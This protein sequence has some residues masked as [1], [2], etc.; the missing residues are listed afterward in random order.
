MKML[1]YSS[2]VLSAPFY[3]VAWVF[4]WLSYPLSWI[5]DTIF[6]ATTVK[7]W[8]VLHRRAC[9][10]PNSVIASTGA[11]QCLKP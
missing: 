11:K 7:A 3:A 9:S 8:T 6:D 4:Y 1:Y 10:K 2:Y 5:G